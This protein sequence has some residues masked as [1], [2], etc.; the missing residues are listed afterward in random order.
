MKFSSIGFSTIV[1]SVLTFS[2][3]ERI[4]IEL[5]DSYT[6]L[7]VDGAITTDTTAHTVM[8]SSTTSYYYNQV[9]PPVT[10][11]LLTL[12]DGTVEYSMNEDAPGIYRTNSSVYGVP[13][14]TYT[15]KIKLA[16]PIGGYVDYEASSILYPV[17]TLDSV[18]LAFHPDWSD[19]GIWEVKCYVQDPPTE[20]FYR[21]L[22]SK[23]SDM[24]TDTLDEWFVTDYRF[25]NGNYAYGAPI[26]YLQQHKDDEVLLTGDTVKVEMNSIGSGYANFIWEAQTEAGGSNPLFSGP[27]ANVKGNISNG[28]FGFFS[29]YSATRAYTIVPDSI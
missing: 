10:G 4:N 12:T 19:D 15:L 7:I 17:N 21:F 6:R 13:G 11:A 26:A 27:P 18:S 25:F 1:L 29:A 24:L 9:I 5:D 8:L 3:V 2:C 16:E 22:I 14:K 20:D 28:A 23:N